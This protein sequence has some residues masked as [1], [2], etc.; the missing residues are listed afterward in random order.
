V[1]G[2]SGAVLDHPDQ[3]QGQPLVNS[4]A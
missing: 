3:Q 1:P 4:I 2:T